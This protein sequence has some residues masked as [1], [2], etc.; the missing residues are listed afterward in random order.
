MEI[1]RKFLE[2]YTQISRKFYR[3]IEKFLQNLWERETIFC[4]NLNKTLQKFCEG[5][6]EITKKF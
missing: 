2:S 6:V 3:N 1:L 5:F 4:G